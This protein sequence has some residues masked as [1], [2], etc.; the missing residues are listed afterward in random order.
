M[1]GDKPAMICSLLDIQG[2]P[3]ALAHLQRVLAGDR[4]AS[5]WIFAGPEGVGKYTTA[6]A[7][8][9]AR[10]CFNPQKTVN[11]INGQLRV[12]GLG[13]EFILTDG[14]G[15]CASCHA[16]ESGSH[17][18]LH[19]VHRR[20]ARFHDRAG[21][22]KATTLGIDVIRGEITGNA[23]PEN[24]VESK[25]YTRAKLGHGKWFI[26]D[27]ADLMQAVAQNAL[28]KAL[29]EPPAGT[30]IVLI[31]SSPYELL[32]T[33]RSRSQLIEFRSL[34]MDVLAAPLMARGL[35]ESGARQLARISEGSLG[36]ALQWLSARAEEPSDADGA[37]SPPPRAAARKRSGSA[38]AATDA[39]SN[40]TPLVLTWI[41]LIGVTLDKLASQQS[42]GMALADVLGKCADQYARIGLEADPLASR[43]RLVR[44]GVMTMLGFTAEWLDDRLRLAIGTPIPA[45][46]PSAMRGL[47]PNQIQQC[48]GICHTAERQVDQNAHVGLLL[49]STATA[50]EHSLRAGA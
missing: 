23:S 14:C 26:I 42:G 8:A 33:I 3:T 11:Q 40:G 15:Q 25:L 44:D 32:S 45:P 47:N 2:Q 22:S 29:E 38:P 46:L 39:V 19:L 1:T 31:T 41:S 27:E 49:A 18:D 24:R 20:L 10:L 13:P 43:D 37:D 50:L 34:P 28:L 12:P 48:V 16:M 36:R 4:M 30:Y 7:L 6:L 17:P 35:N 9:R 5:T 21:K